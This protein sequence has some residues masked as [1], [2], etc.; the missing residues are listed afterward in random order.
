MPS[1][2]DQKQILEDIIARLPIDY[3][4]TPQQWNDTVVPY[5]QNNLL[6]VSNEYSI[7][8]TVSGTKGKWS[9]A[10]GNVIMIDNAYIM[11]VFASSLRNNLKGLS[12]ILTGS[13]LL[14]LSLENTVE[15]M[16]SI[17]TNEYAMTSNI[18]LHDRPELYMRNNNRRKK[19][20]LEISRRIIDVIGVDEGAYV[21]LPLYQMLEE[22]ATIQIMLE[23]LFVAIMLL[24]LFLSIILIYSLMLTDVDERTFEFGMLRALGLKRILIVGIVL[25]Q[26]FI[27]IIPGVLTALAISYLLN[28]VVYMVIFKYTNTFISFDLPWEAILLG[29]CIGTF[30]PILAN[31][32]PIQRALSKSLRDALNL[33]HHAISDI[34]ISIVKLE[35]MGTSLTQALIGLMLVICGIM[36]YY[37]V[38][39]S[40]V[41]ENIRLFFYVLIL[42]LLL[43]V[44]GNFCL[45]IIGLIIIMQI[46]YPYLEKA[47]GYALTFVFHFDNNL[48][49]AVQNNLKGHRSRNAK[50]AFMYTVAITFMV[51]AGVAFALVGNLL[52]STIKSFLGA[53]LIG[54][55]LDRNVPLNEVGIRQY[56]N[57][58]KSKGLVMDFTFV[59]ASLTDTLQNE[60]TN[61]RFN[62]YLSSLASKYLPKCRIARCEDGGVRSRGKFA[63][64]DCPGPVQPRR[65]GRHYAAE[66]W[67]GC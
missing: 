20:A 27:F 62:M 26:A 19:D 32:V 1:D 30:L 25:I 39:Y 6:V 13:D 48:S 3:T 41:F 50:T 4:I 21:T 54:E 42:I 40:L 31:T 51:F 2:P 12:S 9:T 45:D 60:G 57:E 63:S 46:I 35:N 18:V 14:L 8:D 22:F 28:L 67:R 38:P 37:L 23:I 11:K 56:L 49:C 34:Y 5:I 44:L 59:S 24:L 43:M 17:N 65:S 15:Q 55:M 66:Y 29:V 16:E 10:Y 53:D 58:M 47:I 7:V 52:T 33:Y 61:Y 36:A 64:C